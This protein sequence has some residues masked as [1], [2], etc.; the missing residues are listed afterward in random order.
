MKWK[1]TYGLLLLIVLIAYLLPWYKSADKTLSGIEFI[2]PFTLTYFIGLILGV[3]VLFTSYKPIGITI[4]AGILILVGIIGGLIGSG[5]MGVIEENS[6][7]E[8]GA[9][10]VLA[11]IIFIPYII[12]SSIAANKMKKSDIVVETK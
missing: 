9:G 8:T 5:I 2:L 12:V 7:I 10:L 3:I 6:Q 1:I 4:V 11:I